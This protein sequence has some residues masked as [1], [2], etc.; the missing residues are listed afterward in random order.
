MASLTTEQYLALSS[1]AYNNF[2]WPQKEGST[3]AQLLEDEHQEIK[4]RGTPMLKALDGISTW[5]L[6]G[7]HAN[8][9]N[10]F[11]GMAFKDPA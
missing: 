8:P 4:N 1:F 10:G 11:A 6:V 7:F 9:V 5:K 3:I 2:A